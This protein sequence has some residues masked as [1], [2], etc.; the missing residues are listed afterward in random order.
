L[1]PVVGHALPW[2][3]LAMAAAAM[4]GT[5]G[6]RQVDLSVGV[7]GILCACE[8]LVVLIL[9][10]A[11]IGH[12]GAHQLSARPFTPEIF[13]S[14]AP[15]TGLMLCFAAFF[16]FEATTLYSEEAREP[17]RTIPFATFLSVLLIGLFYTFSSWAVINGVG[18]DQ[19]GGCQRY[20]I[21]LVF[22]SSSRIST[23]GLP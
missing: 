17:E 16:G 18:V 5:L 1:A 8:Y 15:S 20:R 19:L 6:Y 21:R 7:L 13:L 22:S 14:G 11:I 2:W 10:C 4:V 23:W 12:R 9:D 3:A